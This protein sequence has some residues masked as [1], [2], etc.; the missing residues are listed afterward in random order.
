[1]NGFQLLLK[2]NN[3]R[4]RII[5]LY[6]ILF[7]SC[8]H[9]PIATNIEVGDLNQDN[10]DWFYDINSQELL[11]QINAND[12]GKELI[13]HLW[14]KLNPIE[15]D[16]IEIFDDGNNGDLIA[17][18][19]IYSAV[20]EN[21]SFNQDYILFIQMEL[22]SDTELKEYEYDIHFNNPVIINDSTYP[23]IA[24]EHILAQDNCTLLNVIIA[25]DD[26]DGRED[27][28]YVR[29]HIKKVNF[30]NG[31]LADS[32][33]EYEPVQEEEYNW[34]ETWV[35]NY[36]STNTNGQLLY[37]VEIPMNPILG[38]SCVEPD[39]LVCGGFGEVQFKFEVKDK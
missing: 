23:Y 6:V 38:P 22:E 19:G 31:L 21:I 9:D 18:N 3:L 34:H 26:E 16:F 25:I 29:Y 32:S 12:I 24:S 36:V 11:I 4:I 39:E 1:M 14:I 5:Y 27:I 10:I 17:D 28:E 8:T 37:Q 15:S 7:Y 13:E 33:C 2:G 20:L 35:M 30:F